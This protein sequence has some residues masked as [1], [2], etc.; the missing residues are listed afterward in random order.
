[1]ILFSLLNLSVYRAGKTAVENRAAPIVSRLRGSKSFSIY[2]ILKSSLR[3][4]CHNGGRDGTGDI[5]CSFLF[6]FVVS[7]V[8]V[9]QAERNLAVP[10]FYLRVITG[11]RCKAS[12]LVSVVEDDGLMLSTIDTDT[13]IYPYLWSPPFF[14]DR[15]FQFEA[16]RRHLWTRSH[17]PSCSNY[18]LNI[19][20]INFILNV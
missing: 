20:T 12:D 10:L 6:C 16:S 14:A 17:V 1:M 18:C 3:I 9:Y 7:R 19:L 2:L 8:F 5:R 4:V 13:L 11:K 15:S